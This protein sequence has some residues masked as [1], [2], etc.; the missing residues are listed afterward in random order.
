MESWFTTALKREM[1]RR[2]MVS[3]MELIDNLLGI[4]PLHTGDRFPLGG[5]NTDGVWGAADVFLP[6]Q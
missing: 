4:R 1:L 3:R 6:P 5:R 2:G